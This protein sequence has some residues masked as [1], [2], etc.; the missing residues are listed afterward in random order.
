MEQDIQPLCTEIPAADLSSVTDLH[1]WDPDHEAST[2]NSQPATI[3][4]H[5]SR[6]FNLS[7]I[8][9]CIYNFINKNMNS[10]YIHYVLNDKHIYLKDKPSSTITQIWLLVERGSLYGQFP[11]TPPYFLS[12]A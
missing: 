2:E 4:E 9:I 6:S 8:Y 7:S 5:P 3:E 12:F 1:F 10:Y 11:R